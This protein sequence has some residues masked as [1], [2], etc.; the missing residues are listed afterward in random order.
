MEI[1]RLVSN[2]PAYLWTLHHQQLEIGSVCSIPLPFITFPPAHAKF[3]LSA[4]RI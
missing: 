1:V 4:L 2:L 3:I